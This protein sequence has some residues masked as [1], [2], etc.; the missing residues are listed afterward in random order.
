M[1]ELNE[2]RRIAERSSHELK[3]VLQSINDCVWNAIVDDRGLF[4]YAYLSP[5]IEQLAGHHVSEFLER[6]TA[7][8][9][10]VHADDQ[11]AY[12][13]SRLRLHSGQS[14]HAV[15]RLQRNDG[16]T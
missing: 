10:L 7:Y 12:E 1:R 5:V 4:Q 8:R 6:P 11:A 13:K 9:E 3:R 15:Y 16:N 14:D 2:S